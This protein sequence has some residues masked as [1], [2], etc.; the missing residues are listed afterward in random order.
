MMLFL[1]EV[2]AVRDTVVKLLWMAAVGVMTIAFHS[3][4]AAT[5][6]TTPALLSLPM[7]LQAISALV[8]DSVEDSLQMEPATVTT[9][10]STTETA[11]TTRQMFAQL[12]QL[13]LRQAPVKDSAVKYP[14]TAA[15]GA[16]PCVTTTETAAK[17]SLT[18]V[19]SVHVGNL[20]LLARWN[21]AAALSPVV[22]TRHA[23][24]RL[25]QISASLAEPSLVNGVSPVVLSR[26]RLEASVTSLLVPS[27]PKSQSTTASATSLLK[28]A[29]RHAPV[30]MRNAW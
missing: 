9:T 22:P 30:P 11:A 26:L 5:T 16:I 29:V 18:S 6:L 10:V 17:T 19:R 1:K 27:R 24:R 15:A 12:Q 28:L 4:T 20:E 23:V 25:Y 21:L 7:S 14:W 13:L 8:K 3:A 2:T